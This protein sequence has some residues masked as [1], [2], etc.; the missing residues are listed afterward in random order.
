MAELLK[1]RILRMLVDFADSFQLKSASAKRS[2]SAIHWP[3]ESIKPF[4]K[5]GKSLLNDVEALFHGVL[6]SI[7]STESFQWD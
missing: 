4:G 3:L 2:F 7:T 6:T 5:T 1:N